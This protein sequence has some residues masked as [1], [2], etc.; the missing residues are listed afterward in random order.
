MWL[1]LAAL[2]RPITILVLTV[3][4][5]LGALLTLARM[6]RDIFPD[7]GIPVIYV[8]QTWPGMTPEQM[9]G[10]LVS[11][12]EYHFLYIAG[13]EHIESQSVQGASIM[14]LYFHPGTDT[15]Y[16]VAQVTAMA[17]RANAFMPPGTVPPFIMRLDAG[18]LPVAD[19]VFTSETRS[20]TEVQDLALFR[21]RPILT[22][23]PGVSAPPP[24]GGKPRMVVVTLDPL[25]LAARGM[26]PEEVAAA[27]AQ[28]NP[29]LPEG[30]VR[31]GS[32][33]LIT[34]TNDVVPRPSDLD[35]VPIRVG[36]GATVYLRD[37]GHAADSSDVVTLIALVN[38]RP[39]VYLPITKRADASTLDVIDEVRAKL[40]DMKAAIPSDIDI[41][42]EF[43][44]SVYVRNAIR[45]LFSEGVLGAC[46]T[47]LMVVLFLRHLR[48]AAI[49]VTS[50][51][52]S[53]LMAVI[54]LRLAGQTINIMTLGGLALAVGILVDEATVAI[55]N[56]HT[57]LAEKKP[58]ARAVSD[59]MREV[60]MPQLVAMLSILA[61]FLPSFFM[62]GAGRA[63]FGALSLAVGFAMV[64]S[65]LA[66]SALVPVLSV[67]LLRSGGAAHAEGEDE[68]GPFAAFRRGYR[69]TL[70]AI[71]RARWG[72]LGV[73]AAGCTAALYFV[74]A[75]LPQELFPTANPDELALR[76]RAADGTRLEDSAALARE[77]LDEIKAAAGKDGVETTLATIGVTPPAQPVSGVFLWNSGPHEGLL[78]VALKR[79]PRRRLAAFEDEL[80]RR[81]RGR[82]PGVAF[83]FEAGDV[84]SQI[85]NS[86]APNPVSVVVSGNDLGALRGHAER[87][88]AE[89]AKIKDLR[90]LAIPMPLDSPTLRIDVD[91]ERAGQ[92]GVT[93]ARVGRSIVE[94]TWSSQL[95]QP[96]FW[97]DPKSGLGYYISLRLGERDMDS[98]EAVKNLPVMAERAP[99]PLLRDLAAVALA[100]TPGEFDH[101]NSI[102]VVRIAA[103]A[104]TSDLG[105]IAREVDA[106]IARAGEPPRG[107]KVQVVG[108]L[109][110]MG[111]TLKGLERGLILAIAVV[112]LLLAANFQSIRDALAV[113]L[114]TPAVVSGV[115][116]ALAATGTS[117]NL[118][119]LMGAIMS[120]GVSVANAVLVVKF[121][122]DR[123]RDGEPAAEAAR[124]AA[125]GRLRPVLMTSLAMLA[126]MV[127]MALGLGESGEQNAPL[128]IA[129]MGG[130]SA[131]TLATLLVLPSILGVIHGRRPFASASLDPDDPES[132]H[133]SP[134]G[135]S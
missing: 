87:I 32:R 64:A 21:V 119:S 25:K 108:Q 16:A 11:K 120:V 7:L 90:D 55:E 76:F 122:Q 116:L 59:A 54:A 2:R 115:A 4:V 35:G 44:Q 83:S 128:G 79:D 92:L 9:E 111:D 56:I 58:V 66:T 52:I 23:L 110:Q 117:L 121:T 82:F 38:G 129:V 31:I 70:G 24:F 105:A 97:V 8:V 15:S 29:T 13:I 75:R 98:I 80:R 39:A 40:S 26:A 103:N 89:L 53:I 63:L 113:L 130:L 125:A 131:S 72:A 77:V 118:Q 132:P 86:G 33:Q 41:R 78:F 6:P 112:T 50:I 106:A 62:V 36:S 30:V 20:E 73:Y 68:R 109:R 124:E 19:L 22:T 95:T 123:R 99:R 10:L 37:V 94:A 71:G 84:V 102:R 69:R 101:W 85:L 126:G 51:P 42:L 127:P 107:V 135:D 12:Y 91:R 3:A 47:G 96:I 104:G 34:K 48:S 74:G 134:A 14:K 88:R 43:D 81:L 1:V 28:A 17:Y 57:H 18:S 67:W 61:V 133:H 45:S 27:M 100:E 60:R 93:D 5:V 49:V 46:L 65:Y 114:I